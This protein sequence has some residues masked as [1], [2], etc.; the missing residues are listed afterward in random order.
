MALAV[1]EFN[2][3]EVVMVSCIVSVLHTTLVH[4]ITTTVAFIRRNQGML[5]KS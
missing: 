2:Y 5:E 1:V 3:A 4:A